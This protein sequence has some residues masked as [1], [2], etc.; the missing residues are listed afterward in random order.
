MNLDIDEA[1]EEPAIERVSHRQ[2]HRREA[3]LEID[4]GGQ[5]AIAAE[6]QNL[7]RLIEVRAHRLLDENARAN[8]NAPEHGRVSARRRREIEDRAFGRQ[9]LIERAKDLRDAELFSDALRSGRIEIIDARYGKSGFAVGGEVCVGNDRPRANGHDRP[10]VGRDRP[11][12]AERGGV[13]THLTRRDFSRD[14][15]PPPPSPTNRLP[16]G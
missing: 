4:R 5:L 1:P 13:K 11:G 14:E 2:H 3:Q 8:G 16:C 15:T 7:G 10:R 6:L 9:R 12:L